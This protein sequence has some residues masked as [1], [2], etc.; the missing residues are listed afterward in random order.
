[1]Y[2]FG[3][4]IINTNNLKIAIQEMHCGLRICDDIT[5]AYVRT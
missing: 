5:I 4:L 3:Q 1:M 2:S